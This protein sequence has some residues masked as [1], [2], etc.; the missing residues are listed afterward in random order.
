MSED[1][2]SDYGDDIDTEAL[3]GLV[4]AAAALPRGPDVQVST[5]AQQR[6]SASTIFRDQSAQI[7][8]QAQWRNLNEP[9]L[10]AEMAELQALREQHAKMRRDKLAR[11]KAQL[12][13]EILKMEH[14]RN[15]ARKA[16]REARAAA[17]KEKAENVEPMRERE[18]LQQGAVSPSS[19]DSNLRSVRRRQPV[20]PGLR[21]RKPER[22]TLSGPFAEKLS[23]A[24]RGYLEEAAIGIAAKSKKFTTK[25]PPVRAASKALSKDA[26]GD[27]QSPARRKRLNND[28]ENLETFSNLRL[29]TCLVPPSEMRSRMENRRMVP[30]PSIA[31]EMRGDDIDGDWVT[32]GVVFDKS[33]PRTSSIGKQFSTLKL[34]DLNGGVVNVFLF[35]GCH[36]A[37]ER[38]AVGS[39]V[40]I[41]NA[42]IKMPNEKGQYLALQISNGD[43]WMKIGDSLD[44]GFCKGVPAEG[45][46]C[47]RVLD[48]RRNQHCDQHSEYLFKKARLQRQEFLSG[49]SVFSIGDPKDTLRNGKK[50]NAGRGTYLFANGQALSAADEGSDVQVLQPCRAGR[51]LRPEEEEDM[52][53]MLLSNTPGAKY[54][55]AAR[56]LSGKSSGDSPRQSAPS[57]QIFS[58]EAMERM[59]FDPVS[60]VEFVPV[61]DRPQ[62]LTPPSPPPPEPGSCAVISV[63]SRQKF[64]PSSPSS[65]GGVDSV[66]ASLEHVGAAAAGADGMVDLEAPAASPTPTQTFAV[67]PSSPTPHERASPVPSDVDSAYSSRHASDRDTGS[68]S[69][70][71]GCGGA[72]SGPESVNHAATLCDEENEDLRPTKAK[73]A[74]GEKRKK[75]IRKPKSESHSSATA[76]VK[77]SA[78]AHPAAVTAMQAYAIPSIAGGISPAQFAPFANSPVNHTAWASPA[79]PADFSASTHAGNSFTV[80]AKATLDEMH[81]FTSK[82]LQVRILGVP[83]Q[84]AKSRVETQIKLCLQLV[85]DKGDKVPLWSHLRL[86]EHLIPRE[87]ARRAKEADGG[88]A[89]DPTDPSILSLETLV[90]CASDITKTVTTCLGCIQRER[91]RAKKKELTVK[92]SVK[93]EEQQTSGD[94][95]V[96]N[97]TVVGDDILDE[98]A[99]EL[100]RKKV[101]LLNCP[102]LVDFSSGDTILPTRITC[103]CRHHNEKVGFCIYFTVRDSNGHIAATGLS[104]PILIT[105]DHK[106]SKS[107]AIPSSRKRPRIDEPLSPPLD[108]QNPSNRRQSYFQPTSEQAS[109]EETSQSIVFQSQESLPITSVS[110]QR[111]SQPASPLSPTETFH[112]SQESPLING[113]HSDAQMIPDLDAAPSDLQQFQHDPFPQQQ[114]LQGFRLDAATLDTDFM[115]GLEPVHGSAASDPAADYAMLNDFLVHQV[116]DNTMPFRPRAQNQNQ[117]APP[118]PAILPVVHRVIP[119]EGPLHGGLEITVLGSG[120]REG[121]VVLFGGVPAT[122]TN[123]WG[124]TTM[125]CVL[126]PSPIAGPVPVLV[127]HD[128]MMSGDGANVPQLDHEGAASFTYK[129]DA[130]RALMELALQ[131]LGL[132][133]T[134]KLEDARHI[135]MRIV[136]DPSGGAADHGGSGQLQNVNQFSGVATHGRSLALDAVRRS[137]GLP[138]SLRRCDMERVL[139]Q[140]LCELQF[141]VDNTDGSAEDSAHAWSQ[142]KTPSGKH[143]LLHLAITSRMSSLAKWIVETR[144]CAVEDA[145]VSGFTALH[146]AAW[147]GMWSLVL[148][149]LEAGSSATARTIQGLLPAQLALAGG[150]MEVARLL[151]TFQPRRTPSFD[152]ALPSDDEE[153]LVLVPEP[154]VAKLDTVLPLPLPS[155]AASVDRDIFDDLS[156]ER[157][158]DCR[159]TTVAGKT[160]RFVDRPR[161]GKR[162]RGGRGGA[163]TQNRASTLIACP[164]PGATSDLELDWLELKEG[165]ARPTITAEELLYNLSPAAQDVE[166]K[167][168][169]D[170]TKKSSYIASW[171]SPLAQ[172]PALLAYPVSLSASAFGFGAVTTPPTHCRE[173]AVKQ[174]GFS[175]PTPVGDTTDA[176]LPPTGETDVPPPPY[177]PA[178]P[179]SAQR[180]QYP[181]DGFYY[182]QADHEADLLYLNQDLADI[183][184]DCVSYSGTHETRCARYCAMLKRRKEAAAI[185]AAGSAWRNLWTFWIPVF[186][187]IAI[188]VLVRLLVSDQ[189]IEQLMSKIENVHADV[190]GPVRNW[191]EDA[192]QWGADQSEEAR[193]WLA[194]VEAKG[195]GFAKVGRLVV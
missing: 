91:K 160:R 22:K 26:S 73:S 156:D 83:Q 185:L 35:D 109:S 93:K 141:V 174:Q 65:S 181:D 71:P 157:N 16:D 64:A 168:K 74:T 126:P 183:T 134:G 36:I 31:R 140:M 30:I 46:T 42:K 192:K 81:Q 53:K 12:R 158:D 131:V 120:F 1:A 146:L 41:L 78:A 80:S 57:R 60:G 20:S 112:T 99:M 58:A 151:F 48:R 61:K 111:N 92:N 25:A 113:M 18:G 189:D 21:Q 88:A 122:R 75:A 8:A 187:F 153:D 133:M 85:T 129:D 170:A 143:T 56:Q 139:L 178:E 52:S 150:H 59:G 115:L 142:H 167:S 96:V 172:I 32:I 63:L 163:G 149:L 15:D 27:S 86:P 190:L 97:G 119:A 107:K 155:A 9:D 6:N 173:G 69:P 54:L 76:V 39:V 194:A 186:M 184:C 152:E 101:I 34:T 94:R 123:C 37:H 29:S 98:E 105:D 89:G 182:S 72:D 67:A 106:S 43:K 195:R 114:D 45:F 28:D 102:Q 3:C 55:K 188:I 77:A 161:R 145:D 118:P 44:F 132:R 10:D 125:V 164:D 159:T 108:L 148:T 11:E 84:N 40:A 82:G 23:D 24:R 177:T 87:K 62:P 169:A 117:I 138:S 33:A 2:D 191:F 7:P 116:P 4:D 147:N 128:Q 136:A 5:H 171:Y 68:P 103:Y 47:T 127:V 49:T 166:K 175:I 95:P 79:F 14:E 144:L 124:E 50:S 121:M 104:P 51:Q 90:V 165:P 70:P 179:K 193:A 19:R 100:E 137:L 176:S 38:E 162:G 66:P 17:S 180:R 110:L 13:E 154:F 130:D 135:A